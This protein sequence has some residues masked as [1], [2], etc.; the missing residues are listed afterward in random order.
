MH[1]LSD[2]RAV[3][4]KQGKIIIFEWCRSCIWEQDF[5]NESKMLRMNQWF[6]ES[7]ECVIL[8]GSSVYINALPAHLK[9]QISSADDEVSTMRSKLMHKQIAVAELE[10]DE[11][12]GVIHRILHLFAPEHLP[13]GVRMSKGMPER[14]SLN[15]WWLE[16]SIPASRSG[17]RDA[18][19][20]LDISSTRG[21]LSR[22][23]GFSL[24]DQ[25]WICPEGSDITWENMNFFDNAFAEDIGDVLLGQRK[26]ADAINFSSP[27]NTSDGNLKKRWKIIDGKRMLI[28][29]G[30]NPFRQQPFNEVIAAGIMNRLQMD[31]IPYS[32]I[33]DHGA[34]YSVCE[35]FVTGETE[36]IP[37]WRI[38]QTQKK[39]NDVSVYQHFIN[40]AEALG[41]PNVVPFL[42]RMIV[43]DYLI[44]NEDRHL[45]N[46]GALRHA[47]SLEWI[48][49]APVYDSG[50][51]LGYDKMPADIME[52]RG[53]TCKPFKK[54]HEKQ[55]D[56]VTDDSWIAFDAL[57]DVRE[58]IERTF[59]DEE[60]R[61][62]IDETRIRAITD[63]V[64]RRIRYLKKRAGESRPAYPDS[65]CNDVTENIA[66]DYQN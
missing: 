55:L 30:S 26:R 32:V 24:S 42:D 33:W 7:G 56:L 20:V 3:E 6:L 25:Y 46:F 22:C 48:G 28:K 51:S 43:L 41:I 35:D 61:K 16:R 5:Y 15:D 37:A 34:P 13:V 38:M 23:F 64:E 66:Q 50:S 47:Q 65:V 2:D 62:Y 31:H 29:G 52:G 9:E 58:L 21:L 10:L 59:S 57:I 44:A 39:A 14:A 19:D 18:L 63:S 1:H 36:L 12:T 4:E 54:T 45:N 8:N 11:A 60:A 40:C 17:I 53:I 49:M 27:D